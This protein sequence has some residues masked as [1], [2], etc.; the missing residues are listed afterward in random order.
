MEQGTNK[1]CI[2]LVGFRRRNSI[3]WSP[4]NC[5]VSITA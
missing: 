5:Y 1:P 2:L 3:L 4:K